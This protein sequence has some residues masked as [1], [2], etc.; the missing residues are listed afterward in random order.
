MIKLKNLIIENRENKIKKFSDNLS[1]ELTSIF[2]RDIITKQWPKDKVDNWQ[3]W[4]TDIKYDHNVTKKGQK[5]ILDLVYKKGKKE[6]WPSLKKNDDFYKLWSKIAFDPIFDRKG[7]V[8]N[9]IDKVL[10]MYASK[11]DKMMIKHDQYPWIPASYLHSYWIQ[12]S[13]FGGREDVFSAVQKFA[14]GI[15]GSIGGD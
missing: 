4:S 11:R 12:P 13:K 2:Y 8:E 7:V 3:G 5:K 9:F 1:S 10:K 14:D 6:L 15:E